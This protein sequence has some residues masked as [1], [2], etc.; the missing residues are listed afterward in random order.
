MI[1][2]FHRGRVR[3][4]LAQNQR[5]IWALCYRMTGR[6]SDADDLAQE[7]AARALDRCDQ[8]SE[9]DATG[10]LLRLTTRLC[11]DHLRHR[12]VERRLTE[13]VD[14]L[15]GDDW[16]GAEQ[17]TPDGEETVLLREDVRFAIVVA[18]QALSPGQ[19]AAL[20]L[21]DVCGRSL[22]EVA[23]VLGTNP[24]AA[25]A[26]LHRAH[27]AIAK[28]RHDVD[29]DVPVDRRAVEQFA[30]AIE[31][32]SIEAITELLAEDVWGIVDGG[33]V[34]QSPTKPTFGRRAV[35]RQ[36]TNAKRR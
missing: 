23:E 17:T 11:I 30:Q 19:R 7:A 10:W 20:I 16:C 6:R 27:V 18:L 24:N 9:D 29:V 26:V 35:A 22:T 5:R 32:G 8:V 15:G 31:A 1:D 28:A 2:P 34:I 13:L 14:P 33:G 25:K 12:N 3:A 21:H 4:A 36:W